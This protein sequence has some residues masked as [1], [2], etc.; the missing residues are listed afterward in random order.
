ML[1]TPGHLTSSI[2]EK[3][4]G[5]NT[6]FFLVPM[7]LAALLVFFILPFDLFVAVT[8]TAG[9]SFYVHVYFDKSYHSEGSSFERFAWYRRKQQL[10]FVHH[11]HANS[12]FAV[13]D[14]FWDRLFRTYRKADT[15]CREPSLQ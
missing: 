9:A 3:D 15:A 13:I 6:P 8:L 1:I 5:N 11:L 10:H 2:R 14:F 12:N 4:G 7:F